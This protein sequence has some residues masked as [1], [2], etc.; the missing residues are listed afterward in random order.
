MLSPGRKMREHSHGRD[1]N[2]MA[3]AE[4]GAVQST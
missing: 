1:V 4:P 2:R 3:F